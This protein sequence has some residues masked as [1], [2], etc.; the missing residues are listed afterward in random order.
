MGA[1][2]TIGRKRSARR[3]RCEL[4]PMATRRLRCRRRTSRISEQHGYA[5]HRDFTNIR[6]PIASVWILVRVPSALNILP[7]ARAIIATGPYRRIRHPLYV[8]EGIASIGFML[9]FAHAAV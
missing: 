3:T 6:A 7:Q 4:E 1:A 8:A 9:Q 2:P 5:P